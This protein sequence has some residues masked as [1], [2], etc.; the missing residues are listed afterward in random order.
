VPESHDL[1]LLSPFHE[2]DEQSYGEEAEE[3]LYVEALDPR[4]DA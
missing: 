3:G 4:L 1:G 2:E